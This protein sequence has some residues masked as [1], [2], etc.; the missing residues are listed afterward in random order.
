M[1]ASVTQ[2]VEPGTEPLGPIIE[3][4]AL[5]TGEAHFHLHVERQ[6]T[7]VLSE[8]LEQRD[9]PDLGPAYTK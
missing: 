2:I 1:P 7:P 8:P 9:E 3:N 5:A 4:R 6:L